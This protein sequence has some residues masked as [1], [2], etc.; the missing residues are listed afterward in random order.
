MQES[1]KIF[2]ED[3]QKAFRSADL[4]VRVVSIRR[5]NEHFLPAGHALH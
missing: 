2:P 3:L 5:N 4:S 1:R